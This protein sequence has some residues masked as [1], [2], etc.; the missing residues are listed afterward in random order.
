MF[1]ART[2]LLL[3]LLLTFS[4]HHIAA[5]KLPRECCDK[6]ARKRVERAESFYNTPKGCRLP[7]VVLVTAKGEEICA[8][9]MKSW[10]K[11]AIEKLQR[12]K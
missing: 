11:T 7:A 4:L 8:N 6:Y 1:A 10:V 3:T 2:V 9:P 5:R 12:K